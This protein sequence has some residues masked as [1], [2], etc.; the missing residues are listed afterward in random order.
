MPQ[1]LRLLK[2]GGMLVAISFHEGEDRIVKN[3]LKKNS[4]AGKLEIITKNIIRPDEEEIIINPR[5][6]SAC[7][8]AGQKI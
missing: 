3:F 5:A 4:Q 7:L 8:R 2:K 6:R 1:A